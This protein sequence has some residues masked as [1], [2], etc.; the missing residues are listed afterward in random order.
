MRLIGPR[1]MTDAERQRRRRARASATLP[2]NQIVTGH[3]A[4]VMAAWPSKSIDHIITSPP[5]WIAAKYSL[6]NPWQSYAH[7]LA[8]MQTV[9]VECARVLRR[10]GKLCIVA[11]LWPL[12]HEEAHR[13][14]IRQHTRPLFD[15]A[16][17]IGRGIVEGTDLLRYETFVWQKQTSGTDGKPMLGA[18]PFAGNSY[19][20]NTIEFINVFV[21]PGKP[22]KFPEAVKEVTRR[23]RR[24]HLNLT[25]Q[26]WFMMPAGIQRKADGSHPAPFPEIL[27]ARLIRLFGFPGEITAD[28]FCGTGTTCAIAKRMGMRFVGIDI[29]PEYV[30]GAAESVASAEVGDFPMTLVSTPRQQGKDE[31][32]AAWKAPQTG[33]EGATARLPAPGTAPPPREGRLRR[34]RSH[35]RG[36]LCRAAGSQQRSRYK[37]GLKKQMAQ[38]RKWGVDWF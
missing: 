25:Q 13:I 36:R 32:E 12:K 29:N 8:D 27:P 10:N 18:S 34:V 23:S 37:Q 26:S 35:R 14:G 2:V 4:E 33:Q 9:W 7:F 38:A 19:A 28:P 31:L 1:A 6:P 15:I 5:Y 17:D 30:A 3:A 16:G 24:E 20:N 22:P 21:K 11:P